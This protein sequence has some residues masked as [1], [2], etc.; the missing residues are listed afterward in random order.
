MEQGFSLVELLITLC[1]IT[2]VSVIGVRSFSSFQHDSDSQVLMSQLLHAIKLARMQAIMDNKKII[3]CRS[4]DRET[5]SG[6]WSDGFIIRAGDHVLN[7]FENFSEGEG[8]LKWRAF[9]L[10]RQQLEF[11]STGFTNSENG[12][13]WF[14]SKGTTDPHWA[15]IISKTGRTR[16]AFPNRNG[17]I[18]DS[19]GKA[20]KC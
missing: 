8:V 15:I 6:D 9:P 18:I 19:K 1:I 3:L 11:L 14:C 10:D 5:C 12:T 7:I 20:L 2:V 17:Y 16:V 13:F 4:R